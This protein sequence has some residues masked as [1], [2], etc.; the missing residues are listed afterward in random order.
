MGVSVVLEGG[1]DALEVVPGQEA[2]QVLRVENTGMVVDRILVD[3]LGDAAE[4]T[5]IEP[6]QVNLLPGAVERVEVAFRPPRVASLAPGEVPYALRVMSTE[7]PEGSRIDEGMIQVG[8]FGDLGGR[9]VPRSATGRRSARFRLVVENHG[10]R[11][12]DIRVET[13]DPENKLGFKTRPS[14]FVA[15]PGTATFVRLK[16]VPRKTFFRGTNRTLPFEVSAMPERGEAARAE[17]VMLEKQTLPEWMLPTLGV[18]AVLC[19]LLL[20]LWFTV[21]R[22]VVHSA[23]TAESNASSAAAQAQH[24]AGSAQSAAKNAASSAKVGAAPTAL[25]VKLASTAVLTGSSD[26]AT[27]TGTSA[28]GA[29]ATTQLVWTSTNPAVAVVSQKGVVTAVS[30]GTA[31]ITAT[32]A[33]G[34]SSSSTATATVSSTAAA[35]PPASADSVTSAS[36]TAGSPSP[37]ATTAT[38]G[39]NLSVVSGSVTIDVVG[40]VSVSTVALPQG[41]LGKTYSESLGGAGG[42]GAFSWS[43]SQGSLPPGFTLSPDGVLS[44]TPTTVGTTTFK[45]QLANSGPPAQF[46]AKTFTLAIVDAPAVDTSSLPGATV[47]GLYTQTLTAVY[48]TAPYT[49]SLVPGQGVLPNG[50]V[51][52]STT[53]VISGTPTTTGVYAF[54]V[55]V[56]DSAKPK[57]S[58][59]Q[60]LSISVADQLTIGTPAKLPIEGVKNSP[61]SLTMNAF[62]GTQPYTWSV[63]SG[64]LPLGLTLNS[65][66]GVISGTPTV[67]GS[68]PLTIQVVSPGPPA[69][70]AA[71]AVTLTVV[72]A[73]AVAVSSLP[74]GITNAVYLQQTLKGAAGTTPYTWSLVPGQ[75][76]LPTGLNLTTSNGVISGTPRAAGT[77]AFTVELSDSTTPS[78][79]ATQHLSI[80]ITNPLKVTTPAALPANGIFNA[81]YSVALSATGGTAPYTWSV[82]A[83][84]LPPGLTLNAVSGVI[85]GTP[86]GTS[87]VPVTTPFTVSVGDSSSPAQ[88]ATE[89]ISL[90]VV[91]APAVKTSSLP[92]GITGAAYVQQTLAGSFGTAPYTWS[93]VPGQGVLPTDLKLDTS[94]GVISG[95]PDAAGTFGFTVQL[96]DAS[97]P[98][99]TAIQHLSITVANPLSISTLE[100]PGGVIGASYSRTLSATGGTAPYTWS[101]STGKLPAG[102][103]LNAASGLISGTPTGTSSTPVTSSFTVSVGDS[104]SPG[105]VAPESV[106]IT[107]V[108]APTVATSSLPGAVTNAVYLPQTLAG[109][110]GTTPYTWSLVPG[111]GVLP[112]DLTLNAGVISGTPS[113][114]GTFSFTVKL[115]DLSAPNLTATRRLSIT[116]ANPLSVSTLELPGGVVNASYSQAL[117]TIGGTAPYTWSVSTG[118][119]PAGLTL[120][121]SN[122]VIS[123]T[124]SAAGTSTFTVS[125]ADSSNPMQT[126]SSQT[127]TLVVVNALV[128]TTSS[129]PPAASGQIYTP[130]QLTATGGSPQYA[131]TLTGTLPTGMSL[132]SNGELIGTPK[133]T[134]VFPFTVQTTDSS[135]PPLTTTDSLSLTVTGSLRVAT[136][137]LPDVLVGQPY[138]HPLTATG[139]TGPYTW[140]LATGSTLPTG[141][142]LDSVTGI[143]SGTT[144]AATS[145][146]DVTFVVTD[147][148]PPSQTATQLLAVVVA[149][150]LGFSV[151]QTPDA[152]VGAAYDLL[153]VSPSGGSGTYVWTESGALPDGLTFSAST[154]EISG[155]VAA[156]AAPGT[157]AFQLTLSDKAG[158]VPP[159]SDQ[160]SI[161]LVKPLSVPGSYNWTGTINTPF[162]QTVQPADGQAPYSYAF[163]STDTVPSWLSIDP[164]TGVVSGTPDA[165]CSSTTPSGSAPSEEFVCPS[166]A[167]TEAVTVTDKLGETFTSTVGLTVNTAPLVVDYNASVAQT[168]GTPFD[169]SVGSPSGGYGSTAYQYTATGLPCSADGTICDQIN[170]DTGD[171]T[172]T[173]S[174]FGKSSY[175]ISVTVTQADPI[176]GSANTFVATYQETINTASASTPTTTS[177]PTSTASPTV[178]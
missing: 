24:A 10:N 99:L 132:L 70:T 59:T 86:T 11:P 20:V 134:G 27:A 75:G 33:G 64:S 82:S 121:P 88:A 92:G 9:L 51:L 25:T 112:T 95:T 74:G 151:P 80:T 54:S 120:S 22:P 66:S 133:Q 45:V 15:K 12:E 117:S 125:A 87:S 65:V 89:K 176:V 28:T 167:Y 154:G 84:S 34:S 47:G 60:Q 153:P 19:G 114:A 36:P 110:F 94:T 41:V 67:S 144:Q 169:F 136:Q 31:T 43:V 178:G 163:A 44:G 26:L 177:T 107:V 93:I 23:A 91:T 175:T 160:L 55:Q 3:V 138:S 147:T 2:V 111:D 98:N 69:Q 122:G 116:V 13:L 170:F 164:S 83:G 102:L 157:Y 77:F 29:S 30:P 139:G 96:T 50:M 118:K 68:Y 145:T 97:T 90:T 49:W 17:G 5:H 105:Q 168:T 113:A 78:Q 73:P 18:L 150:P 101:V 173:L 149:Q 155:T 39:T 129:L 123:G 57:Q 76:L 141:L 148:G 161:T 124:P 14:A 46:A 135:S 131:W 71:K 115:T 140:S 21:L 52:D 128:D 81:P 58:A 108:A 171:V 143:I 7:D 56:T 61:Y 119:L 1:S 48:G 104:S 72:N 32:S 159:Q 152:V 16:T 38:P 126:A 53:G 158:G 130:L 106:S 142:S 137:S 165:Q 166:A 85:S 62:G 156:T 79:P 6:A 40:P 8:E 127:L 100:L 162:H 103:T 146:G 37:T 172:G 4:W 63:S 35:D 174:S 109:S 42:T